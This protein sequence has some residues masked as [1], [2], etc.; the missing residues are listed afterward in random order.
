MDTFRIKAVIAAKEA[1]SLKKAA[2]KLDYTPSAFS[3]I[4]SGLEA[5]LGVKIFYKSYKGVTL[6]EEGRELYPLFC[7]FYGSYENIREKAETLSHTGSAVI[8]IGA[9]ASI[10]KCVLPDLIK[11]F[12]AAYPN[13]KTE[14][15]VGDDFEELL[16]SGATDLFFCDGKRE[17]LA[18]LPLFT[19]G[20]VAV[21]SREVP[22]TEKTIVKERLLSLPLII[23]KEESVAE[24][25]GNAAKSVTTVDSMD[26]SAALSMAERGLGVTIVPEIEVRG[27]KRLRAAKINPPLRRTIGVSYRAAKTGNRVFAEFVSF[28]KDY[29]STGKGKRI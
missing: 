7:E 19:E 9:L 2:E 22:L 28:L 8:K 23:T 10:A 12:N 26:Y 6:T 5:E 16:A 15:V 3:H 17:G 4:I 20:Y 11:K 18:F 13:V 24:Y 21:C 1:G 14:I 25:L 27:L 29:F